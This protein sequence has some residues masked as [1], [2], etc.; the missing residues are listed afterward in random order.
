MNVCHVFLSSEECVLLHTM[1]FSSWKI[2]E[3]AGINRMGRGG[4]MGQRYL[5]E[6][7]NV[8]DQG[9]KLLETIGNIFLKWSLPP[10]GQLSKRD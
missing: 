2:L 10:P 8:G 3:G 9:N 4:G 6:F 5:L 7:G 1:C